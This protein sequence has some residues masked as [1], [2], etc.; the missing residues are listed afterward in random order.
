[1]HH[2]RYQKAVDDITF[3][4]EA[5]EKRFDF[6]SATPE[7][8]ATFRNTRSRMLIDR[9]KC[10]LHLF[11]QS[12]PNVMVTL[13]KLRGTVKGRKPPVEQATSVNKAF[14]EDLLYRVKVSGEAVLIRML[15]DF[16]LARS[17]SQRAKHEIDPL[18]H[19]L[20]ATVNEHLRQQ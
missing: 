4:I 10:A 1:M 20:K 11:L 18:L 14:V 2:G 19:T 3:F 13:P 15:E 17:E 6:N 5:S 9:G 16:L 8:I 12:H 7:A